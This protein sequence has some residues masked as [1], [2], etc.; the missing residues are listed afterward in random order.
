MTIRDKLLIPVCVQPLTLLLALGLIVSSIKASHHS[1]QED[2]RLAEVVAELQTARQLTTE[3]TQCVAPSR[4]LERNLQN[5]VGHLQSA[6]DA[7]EATRVAALGSELKRMSE[8][9]A[10]NQGITKEVTELTTLSQA[11]SDQYI[12]QVVAK[13]ADGETEKSVTT[14]ERLVIGGAHTNTT[15]NGAIQKLFY[16]MLSDFKAKDE[17]LAFI[18]QTLKNTIEDMKKLDHTPFAALP[19]KA[20]AAN[21]QVN[22]LVKEYITNVEQINNIQARAE[23]EL[24]SL[25]ADIGASTQRSRAQ[26]AHSI[27]SAFVTIATIILVAGMAT[28]VLNTLLGRQ[29]ARSLRAT[30]GMLREISEGDGDLTKRLPIASRDEVGSLA[31]HFNR[32]VDKLQNTI[33]GVADS[34]NTLA[35]AS[36]ELSVTASQLA[37]GAEDTTSQSATVAAAAAEMTTNMNTM[38]AASEAMST[39]VKTVALAVDQLTASIGEIARSAEQAASVAQSAAQLAHNSNEKI[40]RLGSSADEI[41]KV[42]EVIE[43]IAEQ[44]NLLALNATI[45]AARAGDAGKGFAV[46][47]S[48]VKELAKQ[49]A[50]ATDDIRKRIEGIQGS[51]GETVTSIGQIGEVIKQV[52]E[53]SRV[54]ASAVEEQSITTKEIAQSVAQTKA[55]AEEVSRGVTESATASQQISTNIVHVDEAAQRAA[56]GASQTR[57]AGQSLSRLADQLQ[58]L[59]SEFSI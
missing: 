51:T 30:T 18:A 38:A 42:I 53:L 43:E 2:A 12:A 55:A 8:K 23:K 56:Q 26:T 58:S 45:E 52:N 48:E 7:E 6:L 50:T 29:I 35:D 24:S 32:F 20:H 16:R 54:I 13:L 15:C 37:S 3:Y 31:Q 11:Q 57:A 46:V 41:G 40:G 14:L 47:A 21:T 39:N 34:T 25:A 19:Q 17:L 33:R 10:R 1:L 36:N 4:E 49:T 22:D 9:K 59:M 5:T 44:T 27:T 28:M